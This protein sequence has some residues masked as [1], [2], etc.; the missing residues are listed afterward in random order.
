MKIGIIGA[1]FVAKAIGGL[2]LKAGHEVMISNSR[3]PQTLFSTTRLTGLTAGSVNEAIAFG[4][5]VVIA[6]PFAAYPTIPS[7]SLAG[8]IV[9]DTNNYYHERDGQIAVLDNKETSTSEMLAKHLPASDIVKAFN[10]I[11]MTDLE[12]DGQAKNSPDRRALPIAGDNK[13][14]KALITDLIDSFGYD[15]VDVGPLSEGWRFERN[16]P[17]YCIP[18]NKA[19]LTQQLADTQR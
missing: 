13:N 18:L 17:V 4:D 14:A 5:I 19:Q 7:A 8:K 6:I 2:A 9:V 1:G 12:K 15:V 10:A 3:G 11:V 16:T